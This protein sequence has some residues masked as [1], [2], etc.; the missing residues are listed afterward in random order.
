[1]LV[2]AARRELLAGILMENFYSIFADKSSDIAIKE[3]LSFSVR[4]CSG[5]YEL[6]EDFLGIVECMDDLS[7]DSLLYYMMIVCQRILLD[8]QKMVVMGFDGAAAMKP[9]AQK[10][11][12][13]IARSAIY[14]HCSAH[15]NELIV[16]DAMQESGLLST[17]LDLCPSMY[18]IFGHIQSA[19]CFLRLRSHDI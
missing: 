7:T 2:L 12:S 9:L 14:V 15:D 10:L 16:K 1:M 19:Y 3:Q 8:G 18:A 17:S 11:K 4:T 6:F 5:N 13:K